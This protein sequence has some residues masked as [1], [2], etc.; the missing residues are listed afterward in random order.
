MQGS[1]ASAIEDKR[2]R[3]RRTATEI[4][5]HFVCQVDGCTKSYGS[6]GSLNQHMKLKHPEYY[7]QQIAAGNLQSGPGRISNRQAIIRKA[8]NNQLNGSELQNGDEQFDSEN[9][10][11][12]DQS[13]KSFF[14][15]DMEDGLEKDI[16]GDKRYSNS[17]SSSG[18]IEDERMNKMG[19]DFEDEDDEE[20][21]AKMHMM[22]DD[23][24]PDEQDGVDSDE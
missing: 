3:H 24:S 22:N 17:G 23:I 10:D 6:E 7:R 13:S 12:D 2:K 20:N 8:N 21:I 18:V 1:D 5:R 19:E 15:D 4:E 14:H 9:E 11:V 16:S